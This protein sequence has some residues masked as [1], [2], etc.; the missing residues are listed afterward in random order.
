MAALRVRRAS[1]VIEASELSLCRS[2]ISAPAAAAK[3]WMAAAGKTDNSAGGVP[4]TPSAATRCREIMHVAG[5]IQLIGDRNVR[6][7]PDW[8]AKIL[9][10]R[11]FFL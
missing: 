5:G 7:S 10:R 9:S 8:P 4:Y 11:L 2:S 6:V 3:N 1:I